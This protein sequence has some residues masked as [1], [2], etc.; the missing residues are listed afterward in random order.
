MKTQ[1]HINNRLSVYVTQRSRLGRLGQSKKVK[2]GE[3]KASL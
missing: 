2:G 1:K 3:R